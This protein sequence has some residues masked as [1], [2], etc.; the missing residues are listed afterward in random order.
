MMFSPTILRAPDSNLPVHWR[1]DAQVYWL[2]MQLG[3]MQQWPS[4]KADPIAGQ[5]DQTVAPVR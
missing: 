1:F 2:E 5:P 4:L 3:I